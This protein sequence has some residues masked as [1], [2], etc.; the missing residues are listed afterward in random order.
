MLAVD[1]REITM[2]LARRPFLAF[3]GIALLPLARRAAA[4]TLVKGSG[5]AATQRRDIGAFVGI[6][7][8]APFAVV[9]RPGAREMI[10]IVADDNILALVQTRLEGAGSE[11]R[12]QIDLP[13][14]TRVEPRTPVVVTIDYVRLEDLAVGGSGSIAA[15]AM[16][17][18]KLEA[19]IGGSGKI[20]LGDLDAGT[21]SV[22]IGGS[23][24]FRADGKARTLSVSVGGSGRCDAERLIAG[25]VSVSV[26][27][28]GDTRVRA[29]T[30]LR[31]SIAGSGDVYHSGAATPQVAIVGS[32]RVKRI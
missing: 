1:P 16:K 20:D 9:L 28:S 17:A 3:A 15:K 21:L 25:D 31:A 6:A 2:S 14:D 22:A 23:G 26:A 5:V 7:L 10:E 18:T 11:R 29:E 4:E 13:R 30:A 27:G 32:G 12:L 24:T 8:G 19:A